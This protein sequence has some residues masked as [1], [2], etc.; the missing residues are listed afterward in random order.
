MV[1]CLQSLV[2]F[3]PDWT[4]GSMSNPRPFDLSCH[5]PIYLCATLSELLFFRKCDLRG[6]ET[7]PGSI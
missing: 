6:G 4:D 3:P 2:A 5:L 1:L 7:R